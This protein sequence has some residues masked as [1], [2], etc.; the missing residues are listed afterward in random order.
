MFFFSLPD[1]GGVRDAWQYSQRSKRKQRADDNYGLKK[2]KNCNFCPQ[3]SLLAYPLSY[4]A[5]QK[6][7][8]FV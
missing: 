6:V 7:K 3:N 8:S 1:Y 2:F 4:R 5:R